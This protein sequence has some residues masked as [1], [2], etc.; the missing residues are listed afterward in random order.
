MFSKDTTI[1]QPILQHEKFQDFSFTNT[2]FNRQVFLSQ[3]GD[4]FSS[5]GPLVFVVHIV[6]QTVEF[7][8]EIMTCVL[9]NT[10]A[11][12]QDCPLIFSMAHQVVL[13]FEFLDETIK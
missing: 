6:A 11:L 1:G 3:L 9:T 8:D 13:S 7:E 4:F 10:N 5:C 2:T 12:P